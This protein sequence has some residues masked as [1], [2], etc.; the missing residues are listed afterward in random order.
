M[1][2]L[3]YPLHHSFNSR[4]SV[5][6]AGQ[7]AESFLC[8]KF[9]FVLPPPL[10]IMCVVAIGDETADQTFEPGFLRPH[11]PL[12]HSDDEAIWLN[13]TQTQ[14]PIQ[15]DTLMCSHSAAGQL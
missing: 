8:S 6:E 3:N 7:A 13:P 11:P 2:V 9:V 1:Y 14:C 10:Y 15:W 4:F 5:P 12:Y